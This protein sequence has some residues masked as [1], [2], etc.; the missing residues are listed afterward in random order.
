MMAMINLQSRGITEDKVLQLN[1]LL[2]NNGYNIDLKSTV[3]L[4]HFRTKSL[5]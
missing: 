5:H 3:E 2:E 4:D 1:S